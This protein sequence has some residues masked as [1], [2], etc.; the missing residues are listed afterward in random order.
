MFIR[1]LQTSFIFLPKK[2]DITLKTEGTLAFVHEKN[3]IIYLLQLPDTLKLEHV[4]ARE[5]SKILRIPFVLPLSPI[6]TCKSSEITQT[7]H[8]L[9]MA[10]GNSDATM[11]GTPGSLLSPLDKKLVKFAPLHSFLANEIVAYPDSE[12]NLRYG[13]VLNSKNSSNELEKIPVKTGPH[14]TQ[15]IPSTKIYIFKSQKVENASVRESKEEEEEKSNE[16]STVTQKSIPVS[17]REYLDAVKDLL[18][19]VNIPLDL[20]KEQM[21]NEVLNLRSKLKETEQAYKELQSTESKERKELEDF[22]HGS[23]CAI[24][25]EHEVSVC[26][27]SCGHMLCE[28]CTKNWSLASNQV[29]CPFC[30]REVLQLVIEMYKS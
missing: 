18:Q 26:L 22:Q 10:T 6:L 2:K 19:K 1:T 30:R 8:L 12:N 20:D 15:M 29:K 27:V 28:N 23:T 21:M 17:E 24:C 16:N 3:K 7:L 25:K 5:V 9:Q 4:L 13:I 11:R 14:E